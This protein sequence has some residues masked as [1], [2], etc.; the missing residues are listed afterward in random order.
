MRQDTWPCEDSCVSTRD[1]QHHSND[2]SDKAETRPAVLC[3]ECRICRKECST[4]TDNNLES[5]F[6]NTRQAKREDVSKAE[7]IR[8]CE[9]A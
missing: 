8:A 2:V 1:M 4:Q 5:G 7:M 3:P 9:L 6:T